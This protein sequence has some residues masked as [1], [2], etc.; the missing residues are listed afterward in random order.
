MVRPGAG[1]YGR[2]G[3]G[4]GAPAGVRRLHADRGPGGALGDL[5]GADRHRGA[6]RHDGARLALARRESDPGGNGARRDHRPARR[7]GAQAR[8]HVGRDGRTRVARGRAALRLHQRGSAAADAVGAADGLRPGAVGER[9]GS[10]DQHGA[11]APAG[12]PVRAKRS[13]AVAGFTLIEVLMATALMGALLPALATVTAE[14]LPN[15]NRGFARVQRSEQLAFGLE[16]IVSDLSSAEFVTAGR[17]VIEPF[18]DGAELSVTLVR[19]AIGPNTRG[20]LEIVRLAETG[21][22]RGPSLVRSK[23]PFA[24][25]VEGVNDRL[26]I[27]FADPVALVRAPFRVSFS[28]AGPD[29]VWKKTWR[30]APLLPRAVRVTVRDMTTGQTLAASTATLLHVE[31]PV[32]CI[33]GESITDCLNQRTYPQQRQPNAPN[34]GPQGPGAQGSPGP[35]R[36]L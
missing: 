19:S 36:R 14:W 27:N 11:A 12:G 10:P 35:Q 29:R 30:G 9:Q 26:P 7:P 33:A 6:D 16:R 21:S 17:D 22:D 32:D 25:V 15:W 34:P 23:A 18:F 24:P 20:G 31:V 1:S 4:R 13:R 2:A 8:Q 3:A 5:G 28:Y